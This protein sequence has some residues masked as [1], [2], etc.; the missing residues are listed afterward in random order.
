M[1][2]GS[3]IDFFDVAGIE[4]LRQMLRLD[5]QSV[6]RLRN[7][8]LK[9]FLSDADTLQMFPASERL[10]IHS[11]SLFRRLD[12]E[13]DGA[14]K[15]LFRT[16]SDLLI[17]AVILRIATGRSSLCV[18]SQVGC[19]AACD[20]CAT[21]RMG[22]SRNLTASE[23]LDQVVQAGQVLAS[24]RR[25]LSNIVFMGMGEPFHNET[26]VHE[27]V[28]LLTRSDFFDRSPGSL[29]ISTVGIT[30]AMLRFALRFPRVNLALSLHS[31]R[32]D[33]R[34]QIIPLASRYPIEV[35]RE[36]IQEI[37]AIQ[38]C[39]LMLEYLMLDGIN[40]S[41]ADAAELADWADGLNVHINLI[42]YNAV[43]EAA[44]LHGS[45]PSAV[46]SFSE[47]LKRKGFRT[48]TRYSLGSD[49]DAACGQLVRLENRRRAMAQQ[50][51]AR[52]T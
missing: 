49:I 35:L 50:G 28:E 46:Q 3:R 25:R 8:L 38:G 22:I 30:D 19:A 21:G 12:S 45:P 15:L 51:D 18:S 24:E 1:Q 14:S 44:H 4:Q 26:A 10:R 16:E 5:P 41:E 17:E 13:V 27:A 34:S 11:L 7:R 32:Q 36:T 37:N 9:R 33:V 2:V 23:I 40:D 52:S 29:L 20:F 42:P 43:A 48:T 31:V 6:R 39:S 47:F